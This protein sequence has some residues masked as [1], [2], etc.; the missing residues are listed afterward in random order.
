MV[1]DTV[2]LHVQFRVH[3]LAYVNMKKDIFKEHQGKN[4]KITVSKQSSY[5]IG[6]KVRRGGRK[7]K[8]T[9]KKVKRR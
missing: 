7:K 2:N 3:I 5:Y 8:I 9:E 6:I 4:L 1:W